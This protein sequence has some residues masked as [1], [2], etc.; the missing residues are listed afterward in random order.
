MCAGAAQRCRGH[1]LWKR[2][3]CLCRAKSVF[4]IHAEIRR[5]FF[6][7]KCVTR[8]EHGL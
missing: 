6:R 8:L 7:K 4:V 3:L 1:T 2:L 5:A